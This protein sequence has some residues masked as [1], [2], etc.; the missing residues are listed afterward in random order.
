[1]T[2]QFARRQRVMS[3]SLKTLVSRFKLILIVSLIVLTWLVA[4]YIATRGVAALPKISGPSD[5]ATVIS[6]TGAITFAIFS[7]ALVAAWVYVAG[8]MQRRM[9]E[10]VM[11]EVA[12]KSERLEKEFRGRSF[13][14]LGYVIGENSV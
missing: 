10:L 7:M 5:L 14:I 4:F 8:S 12:K 11:E 9:Q 2:E 13:A 6:G 1:M 3:V